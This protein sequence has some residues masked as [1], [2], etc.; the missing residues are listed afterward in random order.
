MHGKDNHT[1]TKYSWEIVKD[2]VRDA[3]KKEQLADRAE[4]LSLSL[5]QT[6]LGLSQTILDTRKIQYNQDIGQSI[7]ESYS[8]V[9]ESLSYNIIVHTDDFLYVNDLTKHSEPHQFSPILPL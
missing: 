7:L 8:R 9:L 2:L 3:E 6:F 1:N 5:M 4:S